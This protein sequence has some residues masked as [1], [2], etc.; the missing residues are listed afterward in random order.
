MA[1]RKLDLSWIVPGFRRDGERTER[2]WAHLDDMAPA[3]AASCGLRAACPAIGTV[4]CLDCDL[5]LE[6]YLDV[7]SME[8]RS[9]VGRKVCLCSRIGY[10][11][12]RKGVSNG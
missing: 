7:C 5:G 9:C 11:R 6:R 12:R 1:T 4:E 8:C 3:T 2:Y 10:E